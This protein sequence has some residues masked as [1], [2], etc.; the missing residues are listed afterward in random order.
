MKSMIA[1]YPA[2]ASITIRDL[3]DDVKARLRVRAAMRGRSM[4][5]EARHILRA[6]LAGDAA[7]G[8]ERT[9]LGTAIHD[10]FRAIGGVELQVPKRTAIRR[11]PGLRK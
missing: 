7:A 3:E 9:D 5:E 11:P 6:S 4:E 8:V 1:H 10:R 2:M